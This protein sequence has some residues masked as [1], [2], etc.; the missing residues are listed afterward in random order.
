MRQEQPTF[1]ASLHAADSR[2]R[3]TY[4]NSLRR[5]VQHPSPRCFLHHL[6]PITNNCTAASGHL[7]WI[8][9]QRPRLVEQERDTFYTQH[10]KDSSWLELYRGHHGQETRGCWWCGTD[11]Q[12][13]GLPRRYCRLHHARATVG[14]HLAVWELTPNLARVFNQSPVSPRKCRVVCRNR[15][16]AT[17]MS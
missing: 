13:V 2:T 3:S 14:V 5:H 15:K 10:Q 11:R 16:S 12:D 8:A 7:Y 4:T 1:A 6:A 9:R 17:D